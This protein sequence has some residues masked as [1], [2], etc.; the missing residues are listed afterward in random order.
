MVSF[1]LCILKS[2]KPVF[3]LNTKY[4][5]QFLSCNSAQFVQVSRI[6]QY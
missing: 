6:L 4:A 1:I 2:D 3:L 5:H